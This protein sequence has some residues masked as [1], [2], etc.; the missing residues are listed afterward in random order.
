MSDILDADATAGL[1]RRRASPILAAV[2]ESISGMHSVG[3][4]SLE[5]MREFDA[6]CLCPVVE[7]APE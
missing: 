7:L 2:H 1:A 3:A 4:V 6:L 5:T